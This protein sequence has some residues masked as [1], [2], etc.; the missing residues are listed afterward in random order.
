MEIREGDSQRLRTLPLVPASGILLH[1]VFFLT[2]GMPAFC[3][4]N[5]LL[6]PD[7][8]R[9]IPLLENLCAAHAVQGTAGVT[10]GVGGSLALSHHLQPTQGSCPRW[11]PSLPSFYWQCVPL[12]FPSHLIQVP[13]LLP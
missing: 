13:P 5:H 4:Q 11:L 10:R 12:P 9:L 8:G 3:W 2:S 1:S 6:W 7:V